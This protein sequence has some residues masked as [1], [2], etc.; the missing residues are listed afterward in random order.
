MATVPIVEDDLQCRDSYAEAVRAALALRLV[1]VAADLPEGLHLLRQLRPEMLL[2]DVGLPSG[3]G[4]ELIRLAALQ[5]P[6]ESIV[7]TMFA[8][9]QVVLACIEAGATGYLHKD[10]SDVDLAAQIR[11]L[12]SGGSPVTPSVARGL[13][14][15][16]GLPRPASPPTPQVCT[17]LSTQEQ[18]VL[19]LYASGYSYEEITGD[20]QSGGSYCLGF[21]GATVDRRLGEHIL[22][23]ISP[24]GVETSLVAI[25]QL[26]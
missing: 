14:L 1:G 6:C 8:D 2:V 16:L 22:A 7:V 23:A 19:Q 9:E 13:L 20:F 12:R 26:H 5:P 24:Q 3:S 18:A 10:A 15:R 25:A 21:G 11:S 4:I 17:A